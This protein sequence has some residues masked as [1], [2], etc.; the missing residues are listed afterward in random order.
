MH[1]EVSPVCTDVGAQD[2]ATDVMVGGTAGAVTVTLA[3][4]DLVVSWLLV[5]VTLTGLVAGT[6]LGAA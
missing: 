2:A 3:E 6:A 1:C 5:A 4:P